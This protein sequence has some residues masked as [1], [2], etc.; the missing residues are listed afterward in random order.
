MQMDRIPVIA[1]GCALL[2]AAL[3]GCG[4]GES[5]NK[6]KPPPGSASGAQG[7]NIPALIDL[8]R[9]FCIP[10]KLMAPILEEMKKEYEGRLYVEFIDVGDNP[11]AARKYRINMI[12]T[13]IFLD[14]SGK[15]LYRHVGF[16]AKEDILKKWKELGIEFKKG[17]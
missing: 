3:L 12:P 14:A 17:Q 1:A 6:E 16:F 9:T 10:C 13:Q 15:E 4:G 5:P 8:G 7:K 11:E 2:A